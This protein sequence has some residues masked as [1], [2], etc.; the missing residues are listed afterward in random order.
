[1]RRVPTGADD[2][3]VVAPPRPAAP[4]R[5]PRAGARLVPVHAGRGA[6]AGPE[7]GQVAGERAVG[8]AL[9]QQVAERG[10]LD[11]AGEHRPAGRV[12]GQ[13][14]EQRVAGAAA[15]EVHDLHRLTGELLGLGDRG[16]ERDAR[17]CRGC[18][19]RR[20][21]A[22]PRSAG[23]AARAADDPRGH[24]AG[25]QER[26]V[27][28][29]D[30]RA[31]G[32]QRGR[33]GEDLAE[34]DPEPAQ[35]PGPQRLAEQPEAHHVAQVADRPVDAALVGEVG[36]AAR[37]GEHRRVELD[38]DQ[39]PG[40]AGDVAEPGRR[41]RHADDRRG[42][43]VRADGADQQLVVDAELGPHGA[44]HA[45]QHPAG[46][47]HVRQ[48]AGRQAEP[49]DQLRRPVAGAGV[50]QAGGRGVGLL[51]RTHAGQPVAEQ[52]GHQQRLP[53]GLQPGLGGQLVER[54]ER[55]ELQRRSARTAG[56]GRACGA[57]R[58]ARPRSGRPGSGG[59]CRRSAPS[60]VEQAVVDAPR[61]RSPS[62]VSP[63]DRRS[64]ARIPSRTSRYRPRASQ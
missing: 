2:Q 3:D 30:T 47:H 43:V 61:S 53:A 5:R 56:P 62:P 25:R 58:R 59:G 45:G 64:A 41:R 55:Q 50:E 9:D 16:G 11:R 21:R 63:P 57:R 60:L 40:A 20:P 10:R 31:A 29:V 48:Q 34:L 39:P 18:S 37:L 32:R 15:D 46:G 35:V 49:L 8:A 24:V 44:G 12:G 4:P 7:R 22:C 27:V 28:R 54:A 52:V 51:G 33:G 42:G 23:S 14:A 17:G 1:M 13:L 38:A 19:G 26:R 6:D 36:P